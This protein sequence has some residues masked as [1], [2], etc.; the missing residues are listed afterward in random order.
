MNI[1]IF[2]TFIIKMII[3]SLLNILLKYFKSLLSKADFISIYKYFMN[4][5]IQNHSKEVIEFELLLDI[6]IIG[7]IINNNLLNTNKISL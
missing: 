3:K 7:A 1:V 2:V 6:Y 4:N 5:Y